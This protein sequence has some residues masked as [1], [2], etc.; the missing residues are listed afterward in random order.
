MTAGGVRAWSA[1]RRPELS[2]AVRVVAGVAVAF[3]AYE[4]LRLPQGYWAV[5]TVVIVTQGSIGGTLGAA[6]DRMIGT[7]AGALVGG[8]AAA[9]RPRTALGLGVAL[10]LC[11]GLTAYAAARSSQLKVAPVTTAIMLLSQSGGS[12]PELA[13]LYRVVEIALGGAI[14]VLATVLVLPARSHDAVVRHSA[15]ALRLVALMLEE[16]AGAAE[17]NATLPASAS[18]AG[19]RGELGAVETAYTDAERERASRLAGHAIPPAV[20]RTLWRVR[21][22]VVSVG[23]ALHAPLPAAIATELGPAAAALLRGE[24]AL[25]ARCAAALQAV[26]SVPREDIGN[27]HDAFASSFEALRN[28]GLTRGLDFDAAGRVFGLAFALEGLHRDLSDLANRV[29][30]VATGRRIQG[31]GGPSRPETD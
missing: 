10:A 12:P 9:L 16:Q 1:A 26:A 15:A 23:R 21:N 30:E 22:D 24:A 28:A 17:R 5:F 14:G 20:P 13:A 31:R 7:L 27:R 3:A 4:V 6:S 8:A 18:H 2:Q 25:A 19:L 29:D 11:I